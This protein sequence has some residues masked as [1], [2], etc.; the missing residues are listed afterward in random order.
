MTAGPRNAQTDDVIEEV[1]LLDVVNHQGA[2]RKFDPDHLRVIVATTVGGGGHQSLDLRI[3]ETQ[4]AIERG[5][6]PHLLFDIVTL[7]DTGT[8][9]TARQSEGDWGHVVLRVVGPKGMCRL[10]GHLQGGLKVHT[11]GGQRGAD[12]LFMRSRGSILLAGSHSENYRQPCDAA[13][14]AQQLA[15]LIELDPDNDLY[16]VAAPRATVLHGVRACS[17]SNL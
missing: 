8:A 13:D 2:V 4:R 16:R 15:T 10:G 5:V 7:T 6:D 17:A 9:E 14:H 12:P 3:I 11:A 1:G